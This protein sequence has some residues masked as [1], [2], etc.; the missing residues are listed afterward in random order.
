MA[1]FR[2]RYPRH[3]QPGNVDN[4]SSWPAAWD[5]V[6]HRRPARRRA[7]ET[8]KKVL[9]GEVDP[10]NATWDVHRTKPHVYYW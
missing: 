6:F 8:T 7:K 3:R 10:D 2:R 1:N 9:R 4:M 5:I